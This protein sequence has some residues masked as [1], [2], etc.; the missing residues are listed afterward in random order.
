MQ[1]RSRECPVAVP[2]DRSAD[3]GR[4]CD[5][6]CI[7]P[8][9][10]NDCESGTSKGWSAT[11]TTA[12]AVQI[13]SSI[14]VLVLPVATVCEACFRTGRRSSEA[15]LAGG[16]STSSLRQT[17]YHALRTLVLPSLSG[18]YL[19]GFLPLCSRICAG[20]AHCVFG[21][22]FSLPGKDQVI[23]ISSRNNETRSSRQRS[24]T[25]LHRLCSLCQGVES[26]APKNK[27]KF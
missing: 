9:T 13:K 19:Y 2:C 17:E 8:P 25:S 14:L 18:R 22:A 1:V 16:T 15:M 26:D 7:L 27:W 4:W 21:I 5:A 6:A 11:S 10:I 24:R 3:V 23:T 12:C 20:L